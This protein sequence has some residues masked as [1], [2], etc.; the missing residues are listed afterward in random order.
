MHILAEDIENSCTSAN[1]VLDGNLGAS[2]G[3]SSPGL[4]LY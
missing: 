1:A 3:A 4:L 2:L